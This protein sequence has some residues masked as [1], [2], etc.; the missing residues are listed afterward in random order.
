MAEII[1]ERD[2][3]LGTD[4]MQ[5]VPGTDAG[6]P[7]PDDVA[8]V[9]DRY[10]YAIERYRHQREAERVDLRFTD[11]DEWDSGARQAREGEITEDGLA[12]GKPTNELHMAEPGIQ[13][14]LEEAREAKLAI[15]LVSRGTKPSMTTLYLEQYLEQIQRESGAQD[16]RMDAFER[17]LKAGFGVYMIGTR[18]VEKNPKL[19]LAAFDQEPYIAPVKDQA[20]V[21]PDPDAE[22]IDKSDG[23]FWIRT[24]MMPLE[25]RRQKWPD[26]KVI[27]D[28]SFFEDPNATSDWY[29]ADTNG[30]NRHCRIAYFYKRLNRQK[31]ILYHPQFGDPVYEEDAPK[32][33]KALHKKKDSQVQARYAVDETI[34]RRVVD[35]HQVLEEGIYPGRYFPFIPVFGRRS[36][37]DG[38]ERYR[39]VISFVRDPC[40][41]LNIMFSAAV[42]A[43]SQPLSWVMGDEMADELEDSWDLLWK[44]PRVRLTYRPQVEQGQL[45]PPP[46]PV[47]LVASVD[48]LVVL[49]QQTRDLIALM[50]GVPQFSTNANAPRERSQAGVE[51]I[52]QAGS[53]LYNVYLAQWAT[54]SMLAEGQTLVDLIAVLF[55]RPGRRLRLRTRDGREAEI[56]IK[57]PFYHDENGEAHTVPH[58]RC[59]GTGVILDE[60]GIPQVD[61][62]CG[63]T[64]IAPKDEAPE[65]YQNFKVLYVDFSEA[66]SVVDVTVGRQEETKKRERVTAMSVLAGAAP[67]YV[68]FFIDQFFR[69]LG[70]PELADRVAK[71]LP[72]AQDDL[73]SA[74]PPIAKQMLA[75]KDAE[76]QAVSEALTQ[77]QEWIRTDRVKVQGRLEEV[78]VKGDVELERE[79]VKAQGELIQ[80]AADAAAKGNLEEVKGIVQQALENI[81]G[82]WQMAM[83]ELE[84][85]SSE[86]VAGVQ[87]DTAL[88]GKAIDAGV[89]AANQQEQSRIAD[90]DRIAG[91]QDG[92]AERASRER[93]GAAARA[94]SERQA[95][96]GRI[97]TERQAGAERASRER[98]G[99]AERG[100]RRQQADAD[101]ASGEREGAAA[102]RRSSERQTRAKSRK[103]KPR[104]R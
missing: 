74:I 95:A 57:Q 44:N 84:T 90:A 86:R 43:L 5:A 82:E 16:V 56:I 75:E 52:A 60:N 77:A 101:R 3:P 19:T 68:R 62:V 22:Q 55:D 40:Q 98:E 91:Q 80:K 96:A 24:Y 69:D 10:D 87:S 70:L 18:Y 103:P 31:L 81:R 11:I 47:A 89:K 67:D 20:T 6:Q 21:L 33:L 39:G 29:D 8:E 72:E 28:A 102:N 64:G 14:A 94:S 36:F 26:K 49:I 93:E 54:I 104:K 71:H 51:G 100:A 35:G 61:E 1:N 58:E 66:P 17:M 12:Y 46:S 15:K 2:I 34:L 9:R 99:A 65:T 53:R 76:L 85:A 59:H 23:R 25:V 92:A 83:K 45:L 7:Y 41:S 27:A 30:R 32:E 42:Q 97:S 50:T 4:Q 63:G 38:R 48:H 78:R 13:F 73:E 37:M 79:R 88:A